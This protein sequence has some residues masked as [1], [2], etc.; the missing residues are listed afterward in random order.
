[1][2]PLLRRGAQSE[3]MY[4]GG[5]LFDMLQPWTSDIAVWKGVSVTSSRRSS[6]DTDRDSGSNN[7]DGPFKG[8]SDS[9]LVRSRL[10]GN[11]I[12]INGRKETIRGGGRAEKRRGKRFV[13]FFSA[14]P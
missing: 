4:G 5:G 10:R 3:S 9:C 6:D 7:G 13:E 12:L 2:L 8:R 14:A 11:S 1:M